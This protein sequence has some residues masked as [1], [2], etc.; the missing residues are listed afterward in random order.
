MHQEFFRTHLAIRASAL[1]F[2][3]IL[4]LVPILALTTSIL[5]GLG[6][7]K[8]LETVIIRLLDQWEPPGQDLQRQANPGDQSLEKLAFSPT[9]ST[10]A[11]AVPAST[12]LH[13][14]VHLIFQYVDRTNFAALGILG[15]IGLIIVVF[16][17]LA[18]IE[19][20]MNAIWHTHQG[21]SLS[22]KIMDYLALLILLPLS[23]NVALAAEAILA[24]KSIMQRLSTIMP[25]TWVAPLFIKLIPFLFIVLTLMVMYLFFPH[26]KVK[27]WTAMIGA[28]FASIFWFIFQKLY[29]SLQVGVAN[30][31][32]IYGSFASVP[33]F[34]VWLQIGWTFILLG[35]SLAY[36]LQ[37][38]HHYHSATTTSSP[39]KHLQLAFDILLTVYDHFA[40]RRLISVAQLEEALPQTHPAEIH[41]VVT[42]LHRGG[43]L[44]TSDNQAMGMLLPVTPADRVVASEVV[45]LVLGDD[46]P[47]PSGHHAQQAIEAATRAADW[48][49]SNP[50]PLAR[51][52]EK[53][54]SADRS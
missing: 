24:S 17:V 36:A 30:Y 1:T 8:Q 40:H 29:I 47:S 15:V 2:A 39:Q 38:H 5:K 51:D 6:N 14:A 3:I 12:N 43:L 44:R 10:D 33:L 42:L 45:R 19:E 20:A 31:N 21:R 28:L 54:S 48:N 11:S 23:L 37:H 13:H 7:D 35:A 22:R 34:L 50:P 16:L 49:F 4:S 26:T 46:A 27:T 9:P 52:H 25:A 53:G 32:A 41:A 18:S